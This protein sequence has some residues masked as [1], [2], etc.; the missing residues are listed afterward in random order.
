MAR[1]RV[2]VPAKTKIGFGTSFL[3]PK[4]RHINLKCASHVQRVCKA[5]GTAIERMVG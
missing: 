1:V 2:V 3:R 4:I 5:A